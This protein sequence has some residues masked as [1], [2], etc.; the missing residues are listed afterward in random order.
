MGSVNKF[1]SNAGGVGPTVVIGP[2]PVTDTTN[3]VHITDFAGTAKGAAATTT[4][5]L[6]GSTDNFGGSIVSLDQ[7]DIPST[8]TIHKSYLRPILIKPGQQFRVLA[9]QAMPGAFSTTVLGETADSLVNIT[10]L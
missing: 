5:L 2:V 6:Q 7:I 4:L 1:A 9:T 8:G 10:D 3:E